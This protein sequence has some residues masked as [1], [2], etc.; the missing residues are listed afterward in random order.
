MRRFIAARQSYLLA[1]GV[2]IALGLWMLT[3]A[4]RTPEA[5]LAT[6]PA[7]AEHGR[8]PM[9]VRVQEFSSQGVRREIVLNGR[10]EPKREVSVRAEVDGRVVAVEVAKG[11]RIEAGQAIARLD[12]RDRP[13]RLKEARALVRQRELEYEAAERLLAQ[14]H[15]SE[16]QLAEAAARLEASRALQKRIEVGLANTLIQAPFEGVLE[17]RRVEVGDYLSSGDIVARVLDEDPM[18]LTG[19]VSQTDLDELV[20]GAPAR[21]RLVTGQEVTGRVTYVA[22]DSDL[23]TRTFRVE[24]EVPNADGSL[25]SGVTSEIII[26][27]PQQDAH[28]LS[29]AHLSLSKAGDIGVKVLGVGNTVRFYEVDIV[30]ATTDGLWVAGLPE[31]V[32]VV[33]VGQGFVA[34]GERVTPVFD[35]QL[36]QAAGTGEA[37]RQR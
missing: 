30:R 17:E 3:G 24:V 6:A 35:A 25:A 31:V 14:K 13:A 12:E 27:A 33:T 19:Y 26:A 22:R 32:Q 21:A 20:L 37:V 18:L 2:V 23:A 28:F 5:P 9:R 7:A 1:A 36:S 29:P 11:A 16:T 15:V 10:T 34:E 8:Q 4:V